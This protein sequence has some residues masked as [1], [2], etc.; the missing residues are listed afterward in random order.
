MNILMMTN[1]YV[2]IVGGIERS[3]EDFSSEYRSM[4]HKVLIVAPSFKNMPEEEEGVFRIPAIQ[5]FNGTDFSVEVPVPGRLEGVLERFSPDIVHSH[6]PFLVGDT[7]LRISANRKIPIVFTH[8]TRYEM[9][10]HYVPGD[11][12][13]LKKFVV[14]LSVGY[15][16]LCDEVIAPSESIE[17]LLRERGVETEIVTIPTGIKVSEFSRGDGDA[18]RKKLG[19]PPEAFCVGYLGRIAQEKN[20]LYLM[21]EVAPFL[22][23]EARA[24]FL[25]VG[26]GDLVDE[27]KEKA[28]SMGISQR[29][30][31]AGLLKGQDKIDAYHAMDVLVFSSKSE[32]QG[33]VLAEAMASGVPVIGIDAPGVREVIDSG[34]NGFLVG[35]GERG[36]FAGRLK[37]L[38][39]MDERSRD[40]F[41]KAA[42]ST[43]EKFAY[44]KSVERTLDTYK[45]AIARKRPRRNTDRS[46]WASSKRAI[47]KE[48]QIITNVVKSA[49]AIFNPKKD[50]HEAGK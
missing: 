48:M 43:A 1:T 47:Q 44:T 24:H 42:F 49:G 25:L 36:S 8:H 21:D 45:R 33:L 28:R 9:N 22:S 50:E 11:S 19:I 12:E 46:T 31:F 39:E 10:T 41:R 7:A 35:N 26:G 6:H 27:L 13:A 5:N 15:C 30:H 40:S 34:N 16:N 18:S 32:T 2:P 3:I 4:G 37:E 23:D 20:M 17:D 14:E 29:T 38:L